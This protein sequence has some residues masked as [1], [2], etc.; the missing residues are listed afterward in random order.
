LTNFQKQAI[1]SS[2]IYVT[3]EIIMSK[4]NIIIITVMAAVS[5]TV[6]GMII[7]MSVLL[8]SHVTEINAEP[9]ATTAATTDEEAAKPR[10][11]QTVSEETAMPEEET[12]EE[13]T[14]TPEEETAEAVLKPITNTEDLYD[15]HIGRDWD[16]SSAF[17]IDT[18]VTYDGGFSYRIDNPV[19][20]DSWLSKK[21]IVSPNTDY[22]FTALVKCT[23]EGNA[24][25]DSYIYGSGA[26]IGIPNSFEE[27]SAFVTDNE[28]TEVYY[29]FNSGD[30]AEIE[31]CLR[32]GMKYG[33]C[34]GTAWFSNVL[35]TKKQSGS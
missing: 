29:E 31:L 27:H 15:W 14:T 20:N 26:N 17:S 25:F 16:G 34:T 30:K 12:P 28:W 2:E 11:R 6:I 4:T 9:A 7:I 23:Y 3:E 22:S 1:I 18:D 21:Y 5:V 35:L 33:T 10:E 24:D 32:Y 13:E 19:Y 8:A